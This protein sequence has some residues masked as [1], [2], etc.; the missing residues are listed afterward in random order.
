[1]VYVQ[2]KHISHNDECLEVPGKVQEICY[3]VKAN[4]QVHFLYHH[5]IYGRVRELY[6]ISFWKT[7]ITFTLSLWLKHLKEKP[8]HLII[9]YY[10]CVWFSYIYLF[11]WHKR[12]S[13]QHVSRSTSNYKKQDK[14]TCVAT[15]N[16]YFNQLMLPWCHMILLDSIN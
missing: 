5:I 12:I 11:I 7:L 6:G 9:S 10:Q 2:Q 1:M 3:L 14:R 8:L 13:Q 15:G 4:F 16:H